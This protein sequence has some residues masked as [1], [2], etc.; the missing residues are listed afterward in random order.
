MLFSW[1]IKIS[2]N[3]T[4]KL[5]KIAV[6]KPLENLGVKVW[7]TF[8]RSAY[9]ICSEKQGDLKYKNARAG[10][11]KWYRNT[12]LDSR[13][14]IINISLIEFEFYC[15]ALFILFYSLHYHE[16]CERQSTRFGLKLWRTLVKFFIKLVF[17]RVLPG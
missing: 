9:G 16:I 3:Y 2:L 15:M 17:I 10:S 14:R 13:L 12:P 1:I 6:A 8:N 4:C 11:L 5:V 7:L